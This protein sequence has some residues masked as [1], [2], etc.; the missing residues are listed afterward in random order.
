M[1]VATNYRDFKGRRAANRQGIRRLLAVT[2]VATALFVVLYQLIS[3]SN[4]A[5]LRVSVEFV[6]AGQ[7]VKGAQVQLAGRK[8]GTVKEISVSKQGMARMLLAISDKSALPL[9]NGTRF[10]IRAVG[11]AGVASRFID[12]SPGASGRPTLKNGDVVS[13][14]QT[15]GIVDLDQVFN[16]IDAPTRKKVRGLIGSS[17]ELFAGSQSSALGRLVDNLGPSMKSVE[18]LSTE[19]NHSNRDLVSLVSGLSKLTRFAA[20][21]SSSI[22]TTVSGAAAA[23]DALATRR[24]QIAN[25]LQNAPEFFIAAQTTLGKLDSSVAALRPTLRKT[26]QL[27][28]ALVPTLKELRDTSQALQ[29]TLQVANQQLP[30]L[31]RMFTDLPPVAETGRDAFKYMGLGASQSQRSLEV[32]RMYGTDLVLG[33]GN[34]L[35]TNAISGYDQRGRYLRLALTMS[36][37]SF[38]SGVFSQDFYKALKVPGYFDLNIKQTRKCPGGAEPPA[39][40]GSNPWVLQD[41]CNPEHNQQSTVND[42]F[43][44]N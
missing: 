3:G 5:H 27:R 16:A 4:E 44:G 26:P 33:I 23:M 30:K 28:A 36:P 31:Q 41:V 32:T 19:L 13:A 24:A 42:P 40:D 12:L 6:D 38:V 35:L 9:S 11:Q 8:V 18:E 21:E 39:P 14:N 29:P 25:G 34:G 2:V 7:V 1:S 17:K 20:N 15:V 22:A 37:Q 10:R 43:G